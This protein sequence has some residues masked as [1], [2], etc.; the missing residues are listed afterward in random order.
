MPEPLSSALDDRL[1]LERLQAALAQRLV[2]P[3]RSVE[4]LD[5]DA[6]E[7]DRAAETLLR[8]RISQTRGLLPLSTSRLGKQYRSLFREYARDHH[9]NGHRA[10]LIDAERFAGWLLDRLR[11][12]RRSGP[13]DLE[14]QE[15]L[16]WEQEMCRV[17]LCTFRVRWLLI[18]GKFR[19]VF[20]LGKFT[21]VFGG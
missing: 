20:R 12:S 13:V 9:F 15:A 17:R 19:L 1:E 4:C 11:D 6:S 14:L 7:L 2:Y 16:R 5:L 18:G 8:K 3:G 21:R 10:I